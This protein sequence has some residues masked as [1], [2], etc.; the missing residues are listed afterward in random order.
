HVKGKVGDQ[1]V[2][3]PELQVD[4]GDTQHEPLPG[5]VAALVGLPIDAKDRAITLNFADDAEQAEIRGK[6]AELTVSFGDVRQKVLPSRDDDF[7]KDTGEADTLD[8]LRQK[9]RELLEKHAASRADRDMREALVKELVKANPVEV[10]PSLVE[11]GID[12]QIQRARLSF[13]MQGV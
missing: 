4:L 12:N 10:A 8:E 9:T 6:T 5:L 13:A 1:D 7:A 3:R 2:D 11:R